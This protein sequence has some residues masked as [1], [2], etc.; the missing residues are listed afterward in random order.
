MEK[1][2]ND[3]DV[4]LGTAQITEPFKSELAKI[5]PWLLTV[6]KAKEAESH[7]GYS[8]LAYFRQI[9]KQVN[10][11][12]L[13]YLGGPQGIAAMLHGYGIEI[14]PGQLKPVLEDYKRKMPTAI[15]WQNE[16]FRKAKRDG[17]VQSRLG[18]KR[19]FYLIH[20]ENLEEI[21]K[22]SV[23]APIQSVASDL[24]VLAAWEIFFRH[25]IIVVHMVHDSIIAEVPK[26]VA[27]WAARIVKQTMEAVASRVYPEIPWVADV[28]IV[29]RLYYNRP[30]DLLAS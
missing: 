24:N 8:Q 15:A 12:G 14:S 19:R 5:D 27:E 9:A 6:K 20:A 28:D 11:G 10:F 30:E 21:R 22:A 2:R 23:N 16:Q 29:D 17:Y 3:E 25:G 7:R 1:Y 18:R 26:E 4:H 13:V